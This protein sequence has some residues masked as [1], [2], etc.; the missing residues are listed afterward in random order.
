MQ[1]LRQEIKGLFQVYSV[2]C[3]DL[4]SHCLV[5]PRGPPTITLHFIHGQEGGKTPERVETCKIST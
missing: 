4:V 3:E 2:I 1:Q 5:G